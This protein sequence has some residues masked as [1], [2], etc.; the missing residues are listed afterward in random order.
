MNLLKYLLG[1]L[2]G[3]N[4]TDTD[5]QGLDDEAIKG[6]LRELVESGKK[7]QAIKTARKAYGFGL[8]EA[9]DFVEQL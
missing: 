6:K 3:S 7:I 9:K 4:D 2:Q 8:K 5:L 1:F